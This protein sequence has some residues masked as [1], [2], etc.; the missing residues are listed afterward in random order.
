MKIW[1]CKIGYALDGDL[2]S[3]ADLPMRAA[4]RKAFEDAAGHEHAFLFSGW[5][6]ELT[7]S[8]QAVVDNKE[9]TPEE[10]A[11]YEVARL[12]EQ[13]LLDAVLAIANA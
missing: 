7:P 1:Q 4:V 11:A 6:A 12:K 3:C 10:C 8:E 9:A 13:G 2:P 5:G